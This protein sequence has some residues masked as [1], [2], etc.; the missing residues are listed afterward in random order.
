MN[1]Q[2]RCIDSN[3]GEPASPHSA[4][5]I[6]A[7]QTLA[8]QQ[9][10]DAAARARDAAAAAGLD[11]AGQDAAAAAAAGT[12]AADNNPI[13]SLDDSFCSQNPS[14]PS[15][16]PP[17]EPQFSAPG[18]GKPDVSQNWYTKRFP[19]GV[20]GVFTDGFNQMKSTPL[21]SLIDSF[22]V[23]VS[24]AEH[25]GCWN[26][27]LGTVLSVNLG[28]HQLCIPPLVM[29]FLKIAF[30]LT[31]LFGARLIVFGG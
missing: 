1:G 20:T 24:A 27:N 15:C 10:A 25:S 7:A 26:M 3:T 13:D 12:S 11:A 30:I 6:A 22:A 17:D 29:D 31:A 23:T 5:A 28:S 8:Q 21:Y 16:V 18:T 9:A 4:S 14:D 19:D 2:T